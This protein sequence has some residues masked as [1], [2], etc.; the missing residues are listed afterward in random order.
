MSSKGGSETTKI[1]DW[2][3][4]PAQRNLARAEEVQQIGYTPYYGPSVAAFNEPQR[5]SFENAGSAA[6]AFGLAGPDLN[7]QPTMQAQDFGN[8]VRAHSSGSLYDMVLEELA[9][10]RPGQFD[11]INNMFIDPMTGRPRQAE[12]QQ[13]APQAGQGIPGMNSGSDGGGMWSDGMTASEVRQH[14]ADRTFGASAPSAPRSYQDVYDQQ[15]ASYNNSG[16]GISIGRGNN[17]AEALGNARST[18][19]WSLF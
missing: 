10:R 4:K 19:S 2:L 15:M 13:A 7:M 16:G 3:A 5:Q 17:A 18:R 12:A 11:A 1:P 14:Q 6:R 9:E 8:G